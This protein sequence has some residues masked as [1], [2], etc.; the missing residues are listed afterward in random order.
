MSLSRKTKLG[1]CL[2]RLR[3]DKED[4]QAWRA[5]YD[6][7]YPRVMAINY[8][9]L[10]GRKDPAEDATQEVM[11]RLVKYTDF[12]QLRTP[13]QFLGYVSAV[14]ESV[15]ADSLRELLR[16][17]VPL[18]EG[19]TER[20]EEQLTPANPEQLA[21]SA[22]LWRRLETQLQPEEF[23]LL[24]LMT[25]GYKDNEIAERMGWSYSQTGVRV[26]RLRA[27]VRILLK[28]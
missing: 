17:V 12:S 18:E 26:F 28:T 1:E 25:E 14:C 5:L 10:G 24:Q 16:K 22:D 3:S 13:E 4:A 19:L 20:L 6:L 2:D 15:C 23:R 7:L 9:R 21:L 27:K 8:R 11:F